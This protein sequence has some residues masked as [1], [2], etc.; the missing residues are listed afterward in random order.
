MTNAC[1]LPLFVRECKDLFKRRSGHGHEY[2]AVN[3]LADED[4]SI[5]RKD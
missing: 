3:L 5:D 2:S 4:E 1:I